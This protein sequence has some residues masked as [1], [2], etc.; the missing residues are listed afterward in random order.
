VRTSVKLSQAVEVSIPAHFGAGRCFCTQGGAESR[1]QT[2]E[3]AI[4]HRRLQDLGLGRLRLHVKRAREMSTLN[5][6]ERHARMSKLRGA[7]ARRVQFLR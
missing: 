5:E 6:E 7:T 2:M 4:D 3:L 1:Q